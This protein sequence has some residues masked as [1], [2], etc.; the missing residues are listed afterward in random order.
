[1]VFLTCI[2]FIYAFCWRKKVKILDNANAG[3]LNDHRFVSYH[4]LVCA[5]SNFNEA[6]LLG[7]GDFGSVFRGCLDDGLLVEIK[8]LNL[9]VEGLSKGFEA[10]CKILRMVQQRNLIKTMSL[11]SNLDL[12]LFFFSSCQKEI[13]HKWLYFDNYFLNL[14][15][16]LNIMVDISVA[17]EYLHHHQPHIV[18]HCN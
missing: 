5:I 2:C 10:E 3:N 4:E 9:E 15:Q 18:L 14:H 13:L 8:V 12:K 17:L 1:V 16:R 6:N 11:C 7:R